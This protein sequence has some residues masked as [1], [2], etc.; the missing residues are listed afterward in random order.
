M[1]NLHSLVF[2]EPLLARSPPRG[3]SP[4]LSIPGDGEKQN[5]VTIKHI[6]CHGPEKAGPG[7]RDGPRMRC[8]IKTQALEDTVL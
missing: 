1:I 4:P 8:H 7:R 2:T 6:P 3:S 5:T